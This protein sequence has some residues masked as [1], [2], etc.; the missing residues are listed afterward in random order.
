MK[1][2]SLAAL[3]G[4]ALFAALPPL[5][6][7][8]DPTTRPGV[9]TLEEAWRYTADAFVTGTPV[10]D[11]AA[12][13][14]YFGDWDG[15]AIALDKEGKEVWKQQVADVKQ[16]GPWHGFTG[17]G[18]IAEGRLI[19]ATAS[20]KGTAYALDPDTGS[21]LWERQFTDNPYAGSI[22]NLAAHDGLVVIGVASYE[23][24]LTKMRPGFE[25]EFKGKVVALNADDGTLAW[26]L[27]LAGDADGAGVWSG[28]AVDADTGTLYTTTSNNYTRVNDLSDAIV[29]I[30]AKTGRLKWATQVT[31]NDRWTMA[32]PIGPD[33]A[34][35]A[36][37]VLAEMDGKKMVV[38]GDKSGRV[39]GLDAE[40]G[41]AM[42]YTV[43]GYG[44]SGGGVHG[45]AVV[46]GDAVYVWSNNGYAY[47]DPADTA[48]V[49][50]AR[51]DLATGDYEWVRPKAHPASSTG[52]GVL[53]AD[54]YF[55][56][57]LDGFVRGYAAGDGELTH[58]AQ[59]PGNAPAS[60]S[61]VHAGGL[62]VC[63]GGLPATYAPNP[64]DFKGVVAW[65]LP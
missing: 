6:P 41:E 48:P 39:F 21:V 26:E 43:V 32:N 13:R 11:P 37:P 10:V 24:V 54:R 19:L 53:A 29:A 52:G 16:E 34:F 38:A 47:G 60:T 65:R 22:G 1:L 46:D 20:N 3:A 56:P 9:E 59:I 57:S 12:E 45:P 5:A 4:V 23:E 28:F 62:I 50:V 15:H 55:A 63:G 61:V 58:A 18:V 64:G 33:Y 35:A 40:G 8:A 49:D 17:S 2:R 51:L 7:A 27:D 31:M 42:W 36:P 25:P 30:D 44:G 14:M